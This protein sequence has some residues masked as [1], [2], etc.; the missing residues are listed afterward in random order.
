MTPTPPPWLASSLFKFYCKIVII[1]IHYSALAITFVFRKLLLCWHCDKLPLLAS[2]CSGGHGDGNDENASALLW[3]ENVAQCSRIRREMESI[4]LKVS[5]RTLNK[6]RREWIRVNFVRT[7][8]LRKSDE[9]IMGKKYHKM[10]NECAERSSKSEWMACKRTS[11]RA[12]WISAL[13]QHSAD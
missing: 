1:S 12:T 7:T 10:R 8:H 11:I 13:Q 3:F 9:T 5:I 4:Q 6:V 2:V